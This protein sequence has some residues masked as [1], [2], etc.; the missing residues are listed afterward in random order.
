MPDKV[1]RIFHD[2]NRLL[3]ATK[4]FDSKQNVSPLHCLEE[5]FR[6]MLTTHDGAGELSS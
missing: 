4:H 3:S 2:A 1:E 5:P 6:I